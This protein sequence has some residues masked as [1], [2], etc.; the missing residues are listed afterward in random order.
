MFLSDS[1]GD[2]H[3]TNF[4]TTV[5]SSGKYLTAVS[6]DIDNDLRNKKAPCIGADEYLGGGD[7]GVDSILSPVNNM[8]GTNGNSVSVR[9]V[10]YGKADLSS[11][12]VKVEIDTSYSSVLSV[13]GILRGKLSAKPHDTIVTI[14]VP[15]WNSNAGGIFKIKAYT[16][17]PG[18]SVPADDTTSTSVNIIAAAKAGFTMASSKM[19]SGDSIAVKDKSSGGIKSYIYYLLDNLG[20]KMDSSSKASPVFKNNKGGVY[21][22]LQYVSNS[23]CSDSTSSPLTILQGPNARF[24][25]NILC[26]GINISFTDSSIAGTRGISNYSWH[27]GNGSTSS[28][29]SAST[30]YSVGGSV[31]V[32]LVVTDSNGCSDS[33]SHKLFVN[34][35]PQARFVNASLCR[36]TSSIF[37]DSSSKGSSSI[38]SYSWD[39]GNGSKST[40][41]SASTTYSS[42]GSVNVI[43]KV[44]DSAGCVD[45]MTKSLVVDTTCVW[46]GDANADRVV[47]IKDILN[48]GVGFGTTGSARP[49]ATIA[50]NGQFCNNWSDTFIHAVNYKNA[51]CNGDSTINYSDTLAVSANF[52][53]T[54]LKNVVRNQGKPGDPALT[55]H[56]NRDSLQIGDTLVINVAYGNAANPAKN[57][58]GLCFGINF[59]ASLFDT[60]SMN[61]DYTRSWLAPYGK[62]QLHFSKSEFGND[63]VYLALTR[64]NRKDT[65]G[66]GSI[67]TIRLPVSASIP[68]SVNLCKLT[69]SDN[70]QIDVTGKNLPVYMTDDSIKV[71]PLFTGIYSIHEVNDD[72]SIYPNPFSKSTSINYILGKAEDV[73]IHVYDLT[74]RSIATLV[75]TNETAGSHSVIFNPSS[76]SSNPAG[77]YILSMKIGDRVSE[78]RLVNLK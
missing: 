10:N 30:V 51:D 7:I 72:V 54:H 8:C 34:S 31:S 16:I 20:N 1:T 45:S 2:L 29:V 78:Y 65:S 61:I 15:S 41:S 39:L 75:N 44:S 21:R 64:T 36:Y 53:K 17:L 63:I 26:K 23:S 22:I 11:F 40:V 18:D 71:A 73:N 43:L 69:L 68:N 70:Y 47:D 48:I 4:S 33:V 46:P 58:Y 57:V 13:V 25:N 37:T 60:S 76:Y 67:C 6:T 42:G 32:S 3:L 14:S 62:N 12:S 35:G 19:C 38:T 66:Y 77:I 5:I 28:G 9:V 55:I 24:G 49:G 27:L 52:S 56:A 74:G 50:W 59:N